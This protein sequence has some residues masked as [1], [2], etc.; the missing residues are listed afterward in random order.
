MLIVQK[1]GGSSL[2][3]LSCLRRSASL[4]SEARRRGS[5]LV[6]VVS[7]AGDSTDELISAARRILPRPKARELDALLAT[8]E[9]RSAALMA[10]MLE[11]RIPMKSA[12][13]S[14]T[15]AQAGI[16]TDENHG[17]ASILSVDP[18]RLR[19]SLEA[20]EIAVV[21]G[22]QGE[23]PAGDITTLGRGGSDTTAVALAAAMGADRCEIY[24]DV[25]GVYT[26]DRG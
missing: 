7:A 17:E 6:V 8:G 9:Q 18:V 14:F 25:D 19:Q 13:R 4:A 10:L 15:G 22:F 12:F 11:S 24:T 1:Y 5:D 3:D 2:G 21:A 16:R 20:G 23:S 26:A